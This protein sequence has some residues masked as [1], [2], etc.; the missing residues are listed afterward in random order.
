MHCLNSADTPIAGAGTENREEAGFH[1]SGT[2]SRSHP[3]VPNF[4]VVSLKG[5]LPLWLASYLNA[6]NNSWFPL[7]PWSGYLFLGCAFAYFFVESKEQLQAAELMKR[8]AV[9]GIFSIAAGILISQMPFEIYPA[10]DYWKVNPSVILART[11][12]L[13]IVT[14]GLFFFEHLVRIP[15][16]IPTLMGKE[17]LSIYVLHLMVIYGS[18]VNKGLEHSLRGMLTVPEALVT[19]CVLILTMGA[20]AFV[21]NYMK[22]NSGH[23]A[24]ALKFGLVV[25]FLWSFLTRPY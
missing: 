3:V 19:T 1:S 16:N 9:A 5:V 24:L 8:V 14:S 11:G 20:F 13:L 2:R 15:S 22:Q 7:F 17:S 25:T 18:V 6:G 21:W 23:H 10:H 12:F 4:M